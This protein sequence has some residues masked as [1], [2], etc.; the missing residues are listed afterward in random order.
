[1]ECKHIQERLPAYREE[2]V[3]LE[4]KKAIEQH[5]SSCQ[6][7]SRAFHD[8][9]KTDEII[10]R[11]PEV[12]P[13]AWMTQKIMAR[14]RAEEEKNKGL[15]QRLFYPL[16]IKIPIEV[17]AT[18]LIAVAVVYVFKAVE[19][20]M[21]PVGPSSAPE[22]GEAK[23]ESAEP[24]PGVG[25][26]VRAPAS[27]LNVQR[28][29]G[30]AEKKEATLSADERS[31]GA[32]EEERVGAESKEAVS[33]A[34]ADKIPPDELRSQPAS[35]RK[36]EALPDR[37]ERPGRTPPSPGKEILP[38]GE[39]PAGV[40]FRQQDSVAEKDIPAGELRRSKS[41]A[42]PVK[43]ESAAME[44][45]QSGIAI[46]VKDLGAASEEIQRLLGRIGAQRIVHE[47]LP[48]AEV[49]TA[50][51][52]AEKIKE[53]FEALKPVGDMKEKS[54][55]TDISQGEIARIRIEVISTP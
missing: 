32:L 45:R 31:R 8:L 16:R 39:H 50:E 43:V 33:V 54:G 23:K 40:S 46:H 47:S 22:Q 13:P 53:L 49:F 24:S 12:E 25:T 34:P 48:N 6:L 18:V 15:L 37:A 10:K 7:C 26:D 27:K 29:A 42:A 21:R 19:P 44:R 55:Y 41:L 5:L 4:E 51:L 14:V 28:P 9:K 1:M 20:Q 36:R 52:Q 38:A 11:L 35:A 2:N 17:F 3:D 30:P